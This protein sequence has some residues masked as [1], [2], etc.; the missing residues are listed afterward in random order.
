[1]IILKNEEKNN[2]ATI[3]I[4]EVENLVEEQIQEVLDHPAFENIDLKIMPDTHAGEGCVVGYTQ[5]L[6]DFVIPNI[7]GVD[8]GCGIDSYLVGEPNKDINYSALDEFIKTNIPSGFAIK[9][10]P[11]LKFLNNPLYDKVI[12]V[13]ERLDLD[14]DRVKKSVGTLGGGNHFIEV[15]RPRTKYPMLTIHS[16]SR[17]FG[18]DIAQIYQDK[19]YHYTEKNNLNIKRNLA[20]LP[21]DDGGQEYLDDMRVAQEYAELNRKVMAYYIIKYFFDLDIDEIFSIKT[22][23]N[24]INFE[25]NIIRKGAI[26]ANEKQ[27]LIIPLNM[28][29]GIIMGEGKGNPDWNFSAPHGAGRILSR[30]KAKKTLNLDQFKSDMDNAEVYTSCVSAKTLDESPRAYK[31]K[32]I[33]IDAMFD[34]VSIL[35]IIKPEYNFKG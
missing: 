30:T 18:N 8:I 15:G 22:V 21:I 13:C 17:K 9:G 35:D 33:I 7:I 4:D 25:D 32:D 2:T 3:F 20:Y 28:R 19:A 23:H 12:E 14:I 24:Y 34:S 16:G 31:N 11:D 10:M 29:D 27:H 26:Q 1:M 6:T 5:K